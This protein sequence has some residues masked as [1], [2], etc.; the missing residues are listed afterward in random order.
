MSYNKP[1]FF[2]PGFVN[3]DNNAKYLTNI[4]TLQFQL[5]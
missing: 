3:T 1:I 2:L 4:F 5:S